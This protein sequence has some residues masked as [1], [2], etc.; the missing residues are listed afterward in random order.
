MAHF[1]TI[2]PGSKPWLLETDEDVRLLTMY[3]DQLVQVLTDF[4]Q[5]K[6]D[7]RENFYLTISVQNGKWTLTYTEED[8]LLGEEEIF[9]IQMN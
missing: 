8:E 9:I 2:V 4:D 3:L 1:K 5:G 7:L 6:I